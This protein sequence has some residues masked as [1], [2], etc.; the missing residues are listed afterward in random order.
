VRREVLI[1]AGVLVPFAVLV[2]AGFYFAP[3]SPL[4]EQGEGQG[5]GKTIK[6]NPAVADASVAKGELVVSPHPDPLPARGEGTSFPP[7]VAAPLAAVTPEINRCFADQ[8]LKA[9]R[10][11]K[12][13]FTPT[14][15]GG[16][17]KVEVDEQNPYL[18]AC[19]E[20]VFA[21]IA[22]KPDG[23]QTFSPAAHTFSFDPSPD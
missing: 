11:V 2:V 23:R 3:H 15:D 5:E 20:D 4:P 16:F 10:E 14:R 17:E 19:L 8:H 21:E 22:W 6:L 13:R 7:E 9:R 12:V 1:V 18:A